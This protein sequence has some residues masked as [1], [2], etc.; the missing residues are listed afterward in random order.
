MHPFSLTQQAQEKTANLDSEQA[1]LIAG[2]ISCV[3]KKTPIAL[4]RPP[5]ATTQA[6]GEEGG[7]LPEPDLS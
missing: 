3:V 1:E 4:I 7:C 2:G 5:V 6:I